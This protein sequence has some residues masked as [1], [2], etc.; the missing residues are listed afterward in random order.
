MPLFPDSE[1][2]A[3]GPE[4]MEALLAARRS[5]S[6]RILA[7]YD[8]RADKICN[9]GRY[10][11]I[12][13]DDHLCHRG[14]GLFESMVWR[15]GKI[16]A[17][18]EHL[19][20][21]RAGANFLRLSPPL[22]WD[23]LSRKIVQVVKSAAAPSGEVRLFLGRGCGGFGVSPYECPV[24][25]L[26]IVALAA[27]PPD[28]DIFEKGLSAFASV[29]PPK[30]EYLARIKNTSY[31]PNT[32]MAM[33]AHERGA[34]VA[35]SF[36]SEGNL[37]EAAVANIAIVDRDGCL[38]SP[39]PGGILQGTTLMAALEL[40]KSKMPVRE[41]PIHKD[42]VKTASEILLFTSAS[43]CVPVTTFE[44][45]PVGAGDNKGR[46]GPVA[47]WLRKALRDYMIAA[48]EPI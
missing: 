45:V 30:Q 47:T 33:E 23:D 4:F 26:Y 32:L 15:E 20:R 28:P 42:E 11:F 19:E 35:V 7:F 21:L 1:A 38:R 18:K 12:P 5:G 16:F 2:I 37:G 22:P 43:L 3:S 39:A 24:P 13:L 8:S 27:A 14:D 41:G 40:A 6:E 34:D 10:L 29:I 25:S 36:D 17:F 31:L 9:D 48:G 44:G 46:P